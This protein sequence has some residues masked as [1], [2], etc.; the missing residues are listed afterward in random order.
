MV[1]TLEEY[2]QIKR[3]YLKE[4]LLLI[5][6]ISFYSFAYYASFQFFLN[7][8][9]FYLIV[10]LIS[11][12]IFLTAQTIIILI[13]PFIHNLGLMFFQALILVGFLGF[14]FKNPNFVFF[15]TLV[16]IGLYFHHWLKIS[17]NYKNTL[18]FS[19][20][21]CFQ[22]LWNLFV[23]FLLFAILF[24]FIYFFNFKQLSRESI[25]K[26]IESSNYL[27]KILNLGVTPSTQVKD[28]LRKNLPSDIDEVT[29]EEILKMSLEE[30][31]KKLNLKLKLETTIK[32]AMAEYF[33]LNL[34]KLEGKGTNQLVY[35]IIIGLFLILISRYIL[36]ITGYIITPCA[37]LLFLLLKYFN[38]IKI[39]H[40]LFEKEIVKI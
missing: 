13:L 25:K 37:Y 12:I 31:N 8:N 21:S 38:L 29:Q 5:L 18:K 39:E 23:Y 3:S 22:I 19:F 40:Q 33:Y 10:L 9:F 26:F 4:S 7:K 20:S 24:Y 1:I 16:F 14:Y 15:T 32:E 27:F 30:L 34:Q 17:N 2:S 35:K 6:L 36:L 11:L 28:I